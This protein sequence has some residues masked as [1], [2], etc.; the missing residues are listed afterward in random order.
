MPASAPMA[1][2]ARAMAENRM[3]DRFA[4]QSGMSAGA[5]GMDALMAEMMASKTVAGKDKPKKRKSKK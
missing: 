3:R 2:Y 5:P 1:Q 4:G